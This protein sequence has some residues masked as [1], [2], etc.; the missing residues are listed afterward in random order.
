MFN[1]IHNIYFLNKCRGC[2]NVHPSLL[3]KYR[4]AAP[5]HHTVIN[6]DSVSGCTVVELSSNKYG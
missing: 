6:G 4:G 2:I 1:I 5:L 3:P